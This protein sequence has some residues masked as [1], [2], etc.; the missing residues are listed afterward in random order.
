MFQILPQDRTCS[1]EKETQGMGEREVEEE[2]EEGERVNYFLI[3]YYIASS[4]IVP[5]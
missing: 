2:S 5:T 1:K 3:F 4:T